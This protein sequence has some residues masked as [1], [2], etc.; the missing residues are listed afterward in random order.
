[1][2]NDYKTWLKQCNQIVCGKL[3]LGLMDMPDAT[4]RDYHDDGLTPAEAVDSAYEDYWQD[5]LEA[6]GIV[7]EFA[8]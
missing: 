8:S 4:W 7:W 6:H 3:G 5:E 1:M 2:N